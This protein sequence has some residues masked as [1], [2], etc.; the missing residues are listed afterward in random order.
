MFL[1][2][3]VLLFLV[4]GFALGCLSVCVSLCWFIGCGI[5]LD[6]RF[7]LVYVVCIGGRVVAGLVICEFGFLLLFCWLIVYRL[8]MLVLITCG[9]LRW[10]VALVGCVIIGWMIL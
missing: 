3:L 6:C 8:I 1:E 5:C 4:G 9:G 2:W 7:G 10:C